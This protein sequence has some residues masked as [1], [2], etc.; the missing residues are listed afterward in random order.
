MHV[1]NGMYGLILVEPKEG[2]PPVDREY[3]L[4]QGEFYTT[5]RYGEEGLQAFDMN[6]ATDER[7]TYVVFNGAEFKRQVLEW[8][9]TPASAQL[10]PVG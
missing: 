9:C 4:M 8:Y 7:P 6:K 10:A 3:Y 2:L 5:G 1:G